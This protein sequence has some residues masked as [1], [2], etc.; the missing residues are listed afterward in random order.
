MSEILELQPD[1]PGTEYPEATNVVRSSAGGIFKNILIPLLAAISVTFVLFFPNLPVLGYFR[2]TLGHIAVFLWGLIVF[3]LVFSNT[4]TFKMS[5]K[6]QKY[7]VYAVIASAFA[8]SLLFNIEKKQED[9]VPKKEILLDVY[10]L[11]K[12]TLAEYVSLGDHSLEQET[13]VYSDLLTK[14]AVKLTTLG[15]YKEKDSIQEIIDEEGTNTFVKA[16]KVMKLVKK[17]LEYLDWKPPTE[18]E[19]NT[20]LQNKIDGLN[21]TFVLIDNFIY[22]LE[23][24]WGSTPIPEV[25]TDSQEIINSYYDCIKE[26]KK[27][28]QNLARNSEFKDAEIVYTEIFNKLKVLLCENK[29]DFPQIVEITKDKKTDVITNEQVKELK[30]SAGCHQEEEQQQGEQFTQ[31]AFFNINDK[32]TESI[33]DIIDNKQLVYVRP[34]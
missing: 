19:I 27:M 11:Y 34:T 1:S 29:L 26:L 16:F 20:A 17:S 4:T 25:A 3:I 18:S 22:S 2:K 5:I 24:G 7:V 9:P 14:M 31:N 8:Y 32:K 23:D 33:Q 15:D 6:Q 13:I 28:G 30:S 12:E 21:D 10:S